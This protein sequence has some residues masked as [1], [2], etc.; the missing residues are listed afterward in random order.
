MVIDLPEQKMTPSQSKVISSISKHSNR[1]FLHCSVRHKNYGHTCRHHSWA[2]SRGEYILYVD[3]DDYFADNGVLE[4]LDS[5]TQLWAV[6]PVVK[7]RQKWLAVPP[8]MGA[9]GTGM[10]LHRKEIGRWPDSD[11][12]E[13]DG[14]FVTEL[15]E[16]YPYQVLESRPLVVQ[17]KSSCGVSNAETWWGGLLAKAL[18]RCIGWRARFGLSVENSKP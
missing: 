11:L 9:T 6:F 13:A 16:K 5:V 8:R 15:V 10:F 2:R 14:L 18:N 4:V 3:D 12:Y 1:I 17:P 7:W